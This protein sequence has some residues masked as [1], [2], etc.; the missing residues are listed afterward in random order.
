V[1]SGQRYKKGEKFLALGEYYDA[2]AQF[3]TAYSKIPPKTRDKRGQCALKMAQCYE[4][5]NAT[6]K[7]LAA[8]RNAIRY[9]Q[10]STDTHLAF[11]GQLL[12]N[13]E[14]K[15]AEKELKALLDST[16]DNVLAKSWLQSAM[17]APEEKKEG[18][19]YI[20]KKME[21]FNSRRADYSPMLC[22]DEN[23]QLYFTSTRMR[24]RETRSA[25]SLAQ[26]LVTSSCRK[27]TT[28]ANGGSLMQWNRDSTPSLMKVPAASLPTSARCISHNVP[29]TPLILDM[30]K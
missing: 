5:I 11:A 30:P 20:V 21:V 1:R 16:P 23:Q 29:P 13:G 9:N 26:R 19:R 27:R 2:A 17:A 3:K 14:Y 10:N 28:K 12:K 4:K 22:G 6:Q 18:S 15:T 8:Y 25:A 7:A 24:R